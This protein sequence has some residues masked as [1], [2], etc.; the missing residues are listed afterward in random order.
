MDLKLLISE[1]KHALDSAPGLPAPDVDSIGVLIRAGEW[2]I[3]LETL[4]TQISEYELEM[5]DEQRFRLSRL[6]R[7]L[8]VPV[9]DLL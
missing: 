9:D 4:C 7:V 5:S 8:N 6:G 1:L 3:A 2:E